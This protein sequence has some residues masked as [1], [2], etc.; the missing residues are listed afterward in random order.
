MSTSQLNS[1]TDPVVHSVAHV[2]TMANER[3]RQ[4]G[5]DVQQSVVTVSQMDD[6]GVHWRVNYCPKGAALRRGSDIF[7]NVDMANQATEVL[8]C[9]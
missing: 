4:E 6:D 1:I 2:M 8:L 7:I 5:V 3:A 9:Q